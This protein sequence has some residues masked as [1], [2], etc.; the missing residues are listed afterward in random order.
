MPHGVSF[1][2]YFI[3][4]LTKAW[5]LWTCVKAPWCSLQRWRRA[6]QP[7]A[8]HA[9]GFP[10]TVNLGWPRTH[11]DQQK[12]QKWQS[13]SSGPRLQEG[14]VTCVLVYF[15][16]LSKCVLIEGLLEAFCGEHSRRNGLVLQGWR[17]R[18]TWA[19]PPS[20]TCEWNHLEGLAPPLSDCSSQMPHRK[21]VKSPFCRAPAHPQDWDSNMAFVFSR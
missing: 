11:F 7:S 8:A 18:P 14:L 17:E 3:S 16:A 13:T 5:I 10:A 1:Y 2:Y 9:S 15:A 21:P 4:S 19:Q 6:Q 20:Q 12:V